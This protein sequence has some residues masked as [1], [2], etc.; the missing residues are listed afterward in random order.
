MPADLERVLD[1]RLALIEPIV[2]VDGAVVAIVVGVPPVAVHQFTTARK[3]RE[4][5]GC[6]EGEA[7]SK[8]E[9]SEVHGRTR[10]RDKKYYAAEVAAEFDEL[11]LNR[12]AVFQP[13][14]STQLR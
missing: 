13:Q 1:D 9:A 8:M 12:Q 2:D 14:A 10:R 5:H 11:P 7:A 4:E 6:R 3:Q